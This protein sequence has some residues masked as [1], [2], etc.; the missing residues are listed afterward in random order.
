MKLR[1]I[2]WTEHIAYM[3]KKMN[4][5]RI[6]VLKFEGKNQYEDL[7]VDGWIILTGF[8]RLRMVT[9]GGLWLTR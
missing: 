6:L 8:I 4:V 1:K 2:T 7:D 3:E 5:Y 9:S